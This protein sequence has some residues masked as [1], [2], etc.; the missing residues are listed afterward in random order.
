MTSVSATVPTGL[1]VS[2]V[3]ITTSGTIA[4]G[5]QSGYSIPTNADQA[6]WNTAYGWGNHAGL[7]LSLG[8]G[9]LTGILYGTS[10]NFTGDV[11]AYYSSDRRMKDNIRPIINATESINKLSGNYFEW[12][13]LQKTYTVGDTDIGV[14][15]QEVEAVFPELVI[16]RDDGYKAVR[17]EK[18][19]PVLI[20]AIKEL[21]SRLDILEGRNK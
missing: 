5:L 8:G 4:I 21:S 14:I 6:N 12:N 1:S 13:N 17:Y 9:T 7:Y 10:A 18:I 11:V 15:A 19:I 3:P 16:N 20:E 2:G